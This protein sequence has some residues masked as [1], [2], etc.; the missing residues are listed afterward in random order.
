MAEAYDYLFLSLDGAGPAH[1]RLADALAAAG[2]AGGLVAQFTPQLGWAANEGAV[3]VRDGAPSAVFDVVA[4]KATVVERH[5]LT[6]TARPADG[7]SLKTGGI[8]VHRWFTVGAADVE[9][10]VRLS[11]E[12]WPKFEGQ[13]QT[14]IFGLFTA[15]RTPADLAADQTRLLLLTWYGDHGVWEASRDPTTESMQ[16]FLRR[17]AL[18]RHTRACST[19][20][21]G[22]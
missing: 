2:P 12:A 18:T 21:V 5:R 9:E 17:Q 14:V 16:I 4:A 19:L 8:Y 6:P 15:D 11:A 13:F 10:F 1:R 7:A 22:A 3:L 20:L